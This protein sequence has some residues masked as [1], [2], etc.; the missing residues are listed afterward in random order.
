MRRAELLY[1]VGFVPLHIYVSVVH[2]VVFGA[3]MEFLPL[4]ITS[5]YCA[6]GVTYVYGAL[7]WHVLSGADGKATA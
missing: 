7:Y 4:L 6:L 1:V 2:S 3:G 5:V